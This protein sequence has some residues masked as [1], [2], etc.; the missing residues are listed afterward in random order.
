MRK[1]DFEKLNESIR[2]AGSIQRGETEPSRVTE[3]VQVDVK[4]IRRRPGGGLSSR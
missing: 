2:Q 4:A 1:K 3:F